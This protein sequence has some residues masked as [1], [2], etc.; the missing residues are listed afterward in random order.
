MGNVAHMD[1]SLSSLQANCASL[2]GKREK[3][4]RISA[5]AQHT[6]LGWHILFE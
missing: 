4:A 1:F 6:L 5:L 2:C 3:D